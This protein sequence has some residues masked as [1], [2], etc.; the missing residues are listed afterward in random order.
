MLDVSNHF[1]S[2]RSAGGK[3]QFTPTK[4]DNALLSVR[5]GNAL[6]LSQIAARQSGGQSPLPSKE[7][8]F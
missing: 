8:Q 1:A 6:A 7:R 2:I 3:A 4:Q 5:S